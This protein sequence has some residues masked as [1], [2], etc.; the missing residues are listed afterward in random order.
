MNHS[1]NTE[2]DIF[3]GVWKFC[4]DPEICSYGNLATGLVSHAGQ[5][6]G[7]GPDK[8]KFH[9]PPDRVLGKGLKSAPRKK[10]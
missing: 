4:Y 10:P 1:V 6:K 8:K 9:G 2:K 3:I 5:V 7:D